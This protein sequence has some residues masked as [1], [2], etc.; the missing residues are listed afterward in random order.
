MLVATSAGV[1]GVLFGAVATPTYQFRYNSSRSAPLGW[2]VIV[3]AHDPQ[4]DAYVLTRLPA[5]A[6]LLADE[7]RYLPRNVP[8]LKRVAAIHGQLVCN[9]TSGLAVDGVPIARALAR[10]SLGRPLEA[11]MGCRHLAD[12]EL[13]LL[14]ADNAASF[15]SRYFGPIHRAQ[16]IGEAIPIWTW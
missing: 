1:V 4:L 7:R 13:L 2:Y 14:S 6:A 15:D 3:P 11:W 16:A 10:D 9:T 8:L 12:D 5:A